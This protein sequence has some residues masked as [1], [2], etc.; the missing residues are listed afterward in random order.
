MS[1]HDQ[2]PRPY[3]RSHVGTLIAAECATCIGGV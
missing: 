2:Q 1:A 3:R